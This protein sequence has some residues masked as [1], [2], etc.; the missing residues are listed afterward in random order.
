[1]LPVRGDWSGNECGCLLCEKPTDTRQPFCYRLS[2]TDATLLIINN[3]I[4]NINYI[5][6]IS[7]K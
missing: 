4:S 5:V 3:N 7:S 6:I 2:L 1:M